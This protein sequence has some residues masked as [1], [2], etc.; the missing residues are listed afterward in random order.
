MWVVLRT[1]CGL[2][3]VLFVSMGLAIAAPVV[4]AAPRQVVIINAAEDQSAG[5]SAAKRI[6]EILDADGDLDPLSSGDLAKGF[7]AALTNE[8]DDQLALAEARKLY[9]EAE[10]FFDIK[11]DSRRAKS[12]LGRAETK[13]LSVAPTDE[14]RLALADVNFLY[15]LIHLREQNRGLALDAFTTCRVLDPNRGGLD[16]GAFKP[17]IV[18]AFDDSG[19]R[20]KTP[21]SATIAISATFDVPIFVDGV[22]VGKSPIEVQVAPGKHYVVAAA[23]EYRTTSVAPDVA[24]NESVSQKLELKEIARD[25]QARNLRGRAV[26]H[27]RI[28]GEALLE[29]AREGVALAQVDAAIII[30]DGEDG[31]VATIYDRTPDR[32]SYSRPADGDIDKMFGLL[33]TVPQP[34]L[35]ERPDLFDP[36]TRTP[37]PWIK[38]TPGIATLVGG[39]VVVTTITGLILSAVLSSDTPGN[40]SGVLGG[41]Q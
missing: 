32:L 31:A 6:R 1:R 34:I 39:G 12:P 16:P 20:A 9:A 4:E 41:P 21:K 10:D 36:G 13:L 30:T 17:D 15:G 2:R 7:E 37:T 29:L 25:E 5:F 23:P 18:K 26:G 28:E 19:A 33:V 8:T 3:L 40:R 24:A 35:P 22:N 14:I 38:T 27:G 11:F